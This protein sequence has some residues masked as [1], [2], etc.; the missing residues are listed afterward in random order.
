M[1]KTTTTLKHAAIVREAL[2]ALGDLLGI[3]AEGV[4]WAR[5]RNSLTLLGV[6]GEV[7]GR[8]DWQPALEA[9]LANL[10]ETLEAQE[11]FPAQRLGLECAAQFLL[12]PCGATGMDVDSHTAIGLLCALPLHF[13]VSPRQWGAICSIGRLTTTALYG[14]STL[15][16]S[17][18]RQVRLRAVA[19]V[20][21][22]A[23][24]LLDPHDLLNRVARLISYQFGFYHVGIFL[25][26][27]RGEYAVLK[28][29][30]SEY[31]REMLAH[32]YRLKVGEQGMVGHVIATGKAR[33]AS[34]VDSDATHYNNPFLPNTRSE[35]TLPMHAGGQIIGALDVQSTEADVFTEDDVT[36]LQIMAD[37]LGNALV[38]AR[39]HEE[40]W[41]RLDETRLLREVMLRASAL[42]REE[43][44]HRA[45][46][47]LREELPFEYQA[48]FYRRGARQHSTAASVWPVDKLPI[49]DTPW[50]KVWQNRV[51][52]RSDDGGLPW[53]GGEIRT[54]AAVPISEGED[55][56]AL[57]AVGST[58]VQ[59]INARDQHF[60]DALATELSILLQ[61]ARHYETSVRGA[62]LLR[63]LIQ[64]GEQML[65]ARDV[66][67]VL[68]LLTDA[69][70]A[71]IEGTVEVALLTAAGDIEWVRQAA[72]PGY[73]D[74]AFLARYILQQEALTAPERY[75]GRSRVIHPEEHPALLAEHPELRAIIERLPA[76]PVLLQPLQTPDRSIGFLLLTL[77]P[78]PHYSLE[79]HVAWIQ[80]LANQAAVTLDN[81]QLFHRLRTQTQELTRAYEESRHLSE[82]RA[83]MIQNVSHELR[84]PLGIILGYATMLEDDTLGPLGQQQRDIIKTIYARAQSLNRMVQSLTSLQGRMRLRDVLPLDL[85]DLVHES[86]LEFQTFAQEQNV[87]FY[88]DIHPELPPIPGNRERLHL[89]LTHL[90]ENAIK[91][92]PNGGVVSIR[93]WAEEMWAYITTADQGLG[94]ASEH[95]ERI[96]DCFYQVD[97]STTRRFG[98]MGVG[99][100]L[101]WEI[102]EAHGGQVQV[103]STPGEGSTFI[104]ALPR[105]QN[106]TF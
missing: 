67:A 96:F 81:A 27:E 60:L 48:F 82:V 45:L 90:I 46:A 73:D 66:G 9:H 25:T 68:T 87:Q 106:R 89:A 8:I 72:T 77:T 56:L 10:L 17:T 65:A 64:T 41:L 94:I 3:P 74:S 31:G 71:E 26:D 23:T 91:F 51:L 42:D 97:G 86:V 21:R 79:E 98:G 18:R 99:L 105:Q 15:N 33:I 100:A 101:V 70:L 38:N 59:Q 6:V 2:Q 63:R 57:F 76:R 78:S 47:L 85:S 24:V 103:E 16:E 50:E 61:N 93:V 83:Q 1:P 88:V 84:T 104:L 22:D 30:N 5:H 7:C 102:I 14:M 37:Q 28:S 11:T 44:L 32:Q 36:T 4:G 52:W 55:P 43:V 35:M 13:E 62:A 95:Q 75:L 29:T 49:P 40:V 80:A 92:S 12:L 53:A 34:D 54:L 19:A 58:E 69:L 39:L 20:G